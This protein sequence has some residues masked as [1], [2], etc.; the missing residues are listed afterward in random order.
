MT[1]AVQRLKAAGDEFASRVD[2]PPAFEDIVRSHRRTAHRS[3]AVKGL[4]VFAALVIA[5]G[6]FAGLDRAFRHGGVSEGS[7]GNVRSSA[8]V[9]GGKLRCTAS[10][11]AAVQAGRDTG[12]RF[13]LTNVTNQP[14][15]ATFEDGT[16][17]FVLTAPDG[18]VYDSRYAAQHSLGGGFVLPTTIA[19]GASF[20]PHADD[21]FVRWG[22]PLSLTPECLGRPLPP[23][24]TA[25]RAS[26]AP[27]SD[28][29][30]LDLVVG[31]TGHILD[32]CR[33]TTS[34][35]PIRGRIYPPSGSTPP[36]PATCSI[37]L[38]PE[39]DFVAAQVLIVS[40]PDLSGVTV[41]PPYDEPIGLKRKATAEVVSWDFVVTRD[42]ALPVYSNLHMQSPEGP[43]GLGSA[44]GQIEFD[45]TG[46]QW[47][48]QGRGYECGGATTNQ[49]TG[50]GGGGS[51]SGAVILITWPCA[52]SNSSPPPGGNRSLWLDPLI[53]GTVVP[54]SAAIASVTF[55]AV[56][57]A[58]PASLGTL[59]QINVSASS[60]PADQRAIAW[61]Y[62][63][64]TAPFFVEEGPANGLDNAGLRADASC[65]GD[66]NCPTAG[67]SIVTLAG[68]IEAF[69]GDGSQNGGFATAVIFVRDGVRYAIEGPTSSFRPDVALAIANHMAASTGASTSPS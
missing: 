8:L 44:L 51:G 68:G 65:A 61:A 36:M 29:Q 43:R 56:S 5:V 38:R 67:K 1:D 47:V 2:P 10:I 63:G 49:S 26:G 32:A 31:A 60:L 48:K 7:G 13:S 53:S 37:T 52:A 62:Q 22:G 6:L 42:R 45:W 40:P 14:V 16:I 46:L 23:V 33:P 35:T 28:A 25:V 20:Q 15:K 59:R 50:M 4:F 58:L 54:E 11:P 57:P 19:P 41:K 55:P 39:G 3:P 66:T 24:R 17:G 64:S 9:L 34:G 12:I 18:T 27:T 21:V 69:V 30:A